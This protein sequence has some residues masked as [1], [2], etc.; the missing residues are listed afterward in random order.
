MASV[1]IVALCQFIAGIAT[2]IAM[3][4]IPEYTR[5]NEFQPVVIVWVVSIAVA[6]TV[7]A[8]SLV[9]YVVKKM[10]YRATVTSRFYT[11][12]FPTGFITAI[13][14]I[15]Q[16]IT[17]FASTRGVCMLFGIILPNLYVISLMSSLNSREGWKY[18]SEPLEADEKPRSRVHSQP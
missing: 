15:A 13:I 17:F 9:F 16:L 3:H 4:K 14:A 10:S 18:A 8:G 1:L 12:I 5:F 7:I 2:T 6:D 11:A